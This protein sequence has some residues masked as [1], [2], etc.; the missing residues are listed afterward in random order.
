MPAGEEKRAAT[1]CTLRPGN[2][3]W[4]LFGGFLLAIATVSSTSQWMKQTDGKGALWPFAVD[5][6]TSVF[7]IFLLTPAIVHLALWAQPS[8]TGWAKA[9]VAY[10]AGLAVFTTLHVT[11]MYL[12]RFAIYPLFGTSY[13]GDQS[14]FQT[15]IYEGR[16]D[17]LVYAAIAVSTRI[18]FRAAER[19]EPPAIAETASEGSAPLRLVCRDGASTSYVKADDILWIEAAGNYVE[20]VLDTRRILQ[21]QPLHVVETELSG[22]GFVRIHRSRIANPRHVR[23]I[24]TKGSGDFTLTMVNG[25]KVTGSRRFRH[26]LAA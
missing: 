15:T 9:V 10:A 24:T 20:L 3:I 11:G 18:F 6:L 12:L 19:P 4:L 17:A 22:A 26:I 5:E 25:Q 21:R 13:A 16:K 1:E 8:R 23:T 2:R 14:L 7:L